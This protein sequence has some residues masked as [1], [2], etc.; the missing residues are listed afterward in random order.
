M[1]KTNSARLLDSKSIVY[2]L[3]EYHVDESDLSALSL[4]AKIGENVERIFKTLV[5]RGDKTGIFVAVI[6]GNT[7]VDLKKA[8]KASGNKKCAMIQQKELLG[9]TGYIRGGC[10]PI[11]MK[12][13]YPTYIHETCQLW[14]YI[15]V[16]AGQRGL[17]F[18][19]RPDDLVAVSKSF[20]CDIA[21]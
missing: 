6:P 13:T 3:K 11:G 1:K 19:I 5:L 17:Q 4:A 16:S 12:K 18:K 2:E 21:V 15:F 20:I 8:A 14:E 7:E 9:L 10:S